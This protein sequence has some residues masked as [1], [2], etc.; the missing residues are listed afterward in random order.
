M[1]FYRVAIFTEHGIS[2]GFSW[3]TARRDAE[4]AV[5]VHQADDEDERKPEIEEIELQPTKAGLLRALNRY[6]SHPDN[7]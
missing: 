7:G 5:V 4:H 2:A 1:K 3:H 6:A